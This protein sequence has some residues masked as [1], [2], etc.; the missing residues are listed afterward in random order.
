MQYNLASIQR[1]AR[2]FVQFPSGGGRKNT[3]TG[4]HFS[5]DIISPAFVHQQH[6]LITKLL[7]SFHYYNIPHKIF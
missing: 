2:I 5:L 1:T 6:F 4:S 7:N 3:M